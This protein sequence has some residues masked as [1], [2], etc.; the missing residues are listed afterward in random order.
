MRQKGHV[1]FA[2]DP[3]LEEVTDRAD[4]TDDRKSLAD[5]G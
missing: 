5:H 3:A 1:P 2:A 4:E